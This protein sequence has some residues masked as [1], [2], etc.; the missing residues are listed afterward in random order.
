MGKQL[1]KAT[2]KMNALL[3]RSGSQNRQEAFAAQIQLAVALTTPLEQGVMSGGNL[4][5]IY[6]EIFFQPGVATEFPLDFLTPTKVK[7]HV[8]YV[9]PSHG[10]IPERHVEGD[11]VMVPT[12]EIASS[13]DWLLRYA[14]DARWDIVERALQVLDGSF[15][16]KKN[17]D[18]W[19]TL[20]AA[21]VDRNIMVNDSA[22]TAGR[23][24]KRLVSLL[25][26]EMRRR[27]G[28][29]AASLKRGKLTDLWVSPEAT[30]DMR[31][32]DADDVDDVTR[33]EIFVAPDGSFNK[34]FG[35]FLHELDE[36]GV[37]Q[38]Y[39][40]YFDDILLGTMASNDVEIVVAL[41]LLATDS[42]VNPVREQVR[43]YP[44]ETLHRQRRAGYYGW[45]EH[46][47]SVLDNRRILL[48]SF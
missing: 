35:V 6:E 39:Q 44:D 30:E 31:D 24:T 5:G 45:G 11:F 38:E 34:I 14:R 43:V 40:N 17:D 18:G 21:G 15:T 16:K 32:W 26:T 47:Y 1:I 29:N 27:A 10:R 9:V 3:K 2:D 23:F 7:E 22:A 48:G 36:L 19:H 37:N 12:F 33:R 25:K 28:G 46:G 4:E 20:L 8:A 41:D 42:F 13:I